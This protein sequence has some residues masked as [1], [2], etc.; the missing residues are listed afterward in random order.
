MPRTG[1]PRSAN[2]RNKMIM[3]RLDDTEHAIIT[4]AA[5]RD[6]KA[7]GE[8]VRDAAVAKAKR[9]PHRGE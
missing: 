2:P 3:V 4:D 7:V 6:G 1:R 9:S 5:T 8:Y